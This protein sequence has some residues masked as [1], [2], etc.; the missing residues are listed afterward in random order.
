[1]SAEQLRPHVEFVGADRL[2]P[3]RRVVVAVGHFGNFEL[4][5]RFKDIAPGYVCATTYRAM[6]QPG[7]N[8]LMQSL[9]ERSGCLF[10]E[11]RTGGAA[12]RAAM[13]RPPIIL[14]LLA[15]QHGGWSGLRLPFLGHD[16][17]TSPAPAVFALR[18]DCELYAAFCYRVGLA[19]WRLELGEK[20]PT[21]EDGRARPTLEI[22]REVNRAFETAVRRD[23]T[24]WFWMH[25]RWKID[26]LRPSGGNQKPEPASEESAT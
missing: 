26:G 25:R 12:L 2:V 15:D 23:P 5:P 8:R 9:R 10:F 7:L 1:M 6:K 24:N 16:C 17:S 20:I 13:N 3:P 11:R 14:G 22:M 4:F 21:H 18:Y 19:R